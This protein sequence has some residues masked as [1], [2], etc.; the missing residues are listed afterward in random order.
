MDVIDERKLY[1]CVTQILSLGIGSILPLGKMNR[2]SVLN[3]Y[4]IV[5]FLF[6]RSPDR[7]LLAPRATTEAKSSGCG[8]EVSAPG[9]QLFGEVES[10]IRP[11]PARTKVLAQRAGMD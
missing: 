9:R 3:F 10:L 4:L 11:Q 7:V 1:L 5:E 2:Q 8:A 6:Y